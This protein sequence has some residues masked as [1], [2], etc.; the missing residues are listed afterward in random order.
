MTPIVGRRRPQRQPGLD[1]L[2][3]GNMLERPQRRRETLQPHHR[4]RAARGSMRDTWRH[5]LRPTDWTWM[6]TPRYRTIIP[7]P[8]ILDP[9]IL[10]QCGYTRPD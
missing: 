2:V 8:G 10:F 6:S 3:G 5:Q 9:I 1:G 4:G 7:L